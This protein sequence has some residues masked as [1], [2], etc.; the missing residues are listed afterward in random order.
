VEFTI[1]PYADADL[2]ACR[3]LWRELTQHHRDLYGDQGIGGDDPGMHFDRY[4][5]HA[6]LAAS[7]VADAEGRIVGLT[8][9][10]VDGEEGEVEPVVVTAELRGLGIGRRLLDH[11]VAEARSRGLKSL[12]IRPVARNAQALH[13]FRQ[14][15]FRLL[16]HV[17]LFLPLSDRERNWEDGID[18]HGESYGY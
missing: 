13:S 12:S 4:R 3:E 8:G 16:G 6:R 1:R 9:L 17:E 15:G 7:W 18:L 10:L 14:A 5:T 2:E 11:V